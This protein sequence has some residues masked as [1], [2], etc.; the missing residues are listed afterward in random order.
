MSANF[1]IDPKEAP[2]VFSNLMQKSGFR[3]EMPSDS[4][5]KRLT[6]IYDQ[7][8]SQRRA[9]LRFYIWYTSILSLF[10]IVFILLQILT[11]IM[12]GNYGAE[13]MPEWAL[14]LIIFGMFSQFIGLLTIVTKKVYDYKGLLKYIKLLGGK[15]K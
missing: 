5:D 15:E 6:D 4:L 13:I 11:R 10:V 2:K 7:A 12:T 8:Y 1:V 14:N 9:L 3:M